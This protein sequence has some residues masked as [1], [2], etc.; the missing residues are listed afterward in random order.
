[1]GLAVRELRNAFDESHRITC[2]EFHHAYARVLADTGDIEEAKEHY[3][4]LNLKPEVRP[5][6]RSSLRMS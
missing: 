3:T 2:T 4:K 6:F 1:M 5:A